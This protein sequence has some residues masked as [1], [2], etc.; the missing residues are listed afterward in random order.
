MKNKRLKLGRIYH[1]G[2][3]I[4]ELVQLENLEPR[5]DEGHEGSRYAIVYGF[6]LGDL[7]VLGVVVDYKLGV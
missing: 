5:R 2:T 1:R 4:T 7:L 6:V 3:E